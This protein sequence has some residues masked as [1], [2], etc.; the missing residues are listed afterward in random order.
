MK[1]VVSTWGIGVVFETNNGTLHMLNSIHQNN[2]SGTY[3][4]YSG[5]SY[6][7]QY[8]DRNIQSRSSN[9]CVTAFIREHRKPINNSPICIHRV[10]KITIHYGFGRYIQTNSIQKGG[11]IFVPKSWERHSLKNQETPLNFPSLGNNILKKTTTQEPPPPKDTSQT[12][13]DFKHRN[14]PKTTATP[15]VKPPIKRQNPAPI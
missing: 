4:R 10:Q 14:T 11:S 5:I 8:N 12:R 2:Q 1:I 15:R 9:R 7:A 6:R 13:V 3:C